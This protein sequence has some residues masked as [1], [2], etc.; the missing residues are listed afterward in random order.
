M[1]ISQTQLTNIIKESVSKIIKEGGNLY[2]TMPDGTKFT[3]SKKTYHG[4]PGT[5]FIWHGEWSDPEVWYKGKELGNVE[6]TLWDRY[7]VE[8]K[9]EGKEPSEEEFDNLP[10][11]WFQDN[12]DD[13]VFGME[14]DTIQES[15]TKAI[16]KVLKE[17]YEGLSH[18]ARNLYLMLENNDG[19]WFNWL[20]NALI[21]KAK[22]GVELSVEQLANSVTVKAKIREYAKE[23]IENEYNDGPITPEDKQMAAL[24]FAERM[25]ASVEE[26]K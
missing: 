26:S 2:A 17:D 12:L 25:L 1:K 15:V 14:E 10:T 4:V 7:Q 13:I 24:Q 3:N 6:D 21:K 22:R 11:E 19:M 16:K 5:T 23:M 20:H 8:C 9:E 18:N